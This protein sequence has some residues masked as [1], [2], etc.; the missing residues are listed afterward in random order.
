MLFPTRLLACA[1]LAG[2]ASGCATFGTNVEGDFTCRAPNGDCA[3]AHVIDAKATDNLSNGTLLHADARQRSGVVDADTSRTA[4]RTLRVVFPAHVDEAGTLHDE[5]VAWTVVENPRWATEL[6]RKAGEGQGGSLMRQV[7]RQLKAAQIAPAPDGAEGNLSVADEA[8]PFSSARDDAG[9]AGGISDADATSPF[10][11][12]SDASPL[13]LPS[14]AR[15]AVA[16][17]KAP[18]VEGFDTLPPPRDRAPRPEAGQSTPV[19]PSAAAIEAA[20]AA[21]RPA[22]R[23]GEQP[24]V[25]TSQP[26]EPK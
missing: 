15:E 12:T 10:N 24:I 23:N 21:I 2:L 14:T 26:K 7:R 19:F 11:E 22:V 6:R 17:A 9:Q 16:G 13:V 18:A 20:K 5:A 1:C 4:E 8:S 3:P 25:S